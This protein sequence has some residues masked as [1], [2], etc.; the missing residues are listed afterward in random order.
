[1][2][3]RGRGRR[4]RRRRRRPTWSRVGRHDAA[5]PERLGAGAGRAAPAGRLPARAR[6]PS[7]RPSGDLRTT[8]WYWV[9]S[10]DAAL[11]F[12]LPAG[13]ELVQVRV[14]GEAV[15]QV[16]RLPGKAGYR[17]EPA[18]SG[19]GRPRAGRGGVHRPGREVVGGL[20]PAATARRRGRPADLWE[21]RVPWSRG[22]GRR[23]RGVDRRER[24]VLG[25]LRLEAPA[26]E[27]VRRAGRLGRRPA[28]RAAG[29]GRPG[30]RPTRAATTTAT[31]SA[32][33]AARRAAA[34]GRLA[35][36]AGGGL[37]GERAGRRRSP[38][39]RLAP[40]GPAGLGRRAW[41]SASRSRPCSTRA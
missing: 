10:H 25:R 39:P 22:R 26:L 34:A 27:D 6:G 36:L 14:G 13:A 12:A 32:A 21:V 9:E 7:R 2:G 37:L 8:A 19:R 17:V 30:P 11:S 40:A 18:G 35:G 3:P 1:M 29:P 5:R 28:A 24:V 38:D 4:G 15:R 31:S 33:P 16:E 23:A 20:G 41:C